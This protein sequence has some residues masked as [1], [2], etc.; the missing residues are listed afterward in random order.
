MPP[1]A[2][3]TELEPI[4]GVRLAGSAVA[5]PHELSAGAP[6]LDNDQILRWVT[7][8][9]LAVPD[10]ARQARARWGVW[11]RSWA[12][13][14]GEPQP[15]ITT[16][17]L[18]VAAGRR[19]LRHT[20]WAPDTLDLCVVA[21]STPDRITQSLAAKVGVA[22]GLQC[23]TLDVRGG[24]A[25]GL[26][27]WLIA[28]G[29]LRLG[30][31]RALVIAADCPSAMID[32][33]DVIALLLYADGAAAITL[34]RDEAAGGLLLGLLGTRQGEG[35]A[36]T[37]PGPLPPTARALADGAYHFRAPDA[38]YVAALRACWREV[39]V[40]LAAHGEPIDWF[41]PYRITP[42]QIAGAAEAL[43][44]P[45]QRT[46][47]ELSVHGCTGASGCLVSVHELRTAGELPPG[48]VLAS[49]AVGGGICIGGLL[50]RC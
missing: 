32:P 37:V 21:T 50:W 6:E 41:A 10:A 45:P 42:R 29:W 3:V 27:A 34:E 5:F 31:R 24:G 25:G 48:A 4:S 14:P 19:A 22:L 8:R 49:S 16:Q 39:S 35:T 44:V 26:Q 11:R 28:A 2:P 17:Q 12:R 23:A 20:G 47:A 43:G 33:D 13:W 1:R 40:R 46:H 38:A 18:A 9:G 36:F 30:I 7:D 15:A